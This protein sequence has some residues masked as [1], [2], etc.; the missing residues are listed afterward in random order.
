[1]SSTVP[2]PLFST[3]Q[4]HIVENTPYLSASLSI[5]GSSMIVYRIFSDRAKTLKKPYE[6]LILGLSCMDITGSLG[7]V[8]F[9]PWAAPKE[10]TWVLGARGTFTTCTIKG[11][12]MSS[13][14]GS[15]WYSAMMAIYFLL[16]VRFECRDQWIARRVEL[17]MHSISILLPVV[18][19]TY[20]A[21][22]GY[23][24][25][26]Y[27]PPGSCYV[28]RYPPLCGRDSRDDPAVE[29]TRGQNMRKF[30]LLMGGA[31]ISLCFGIIIVCMALIFARVRATEIKQR[32][33]LPEGASRKLKLTRQTSIQ[34][35]YYIGAFFLCNTWN[36]AYQL[37]M[38]S[39]TFDDYEKDATKWFI[40]LLLTRVFFPLQGTKNDPTMGMSL[41]SFESIALVTNIISRCFQVSSTLTFISANTSRTQKI[42]AT[43]NDPGVRGCPFT[44]RV[45][46]RPTRRRHETATMSKQV[47]KPAPQRKLRPFV[48]EREPNWLWKDTENRAEMTILV[49]LSVRQS[50]QDIAKPCL[51][52]AVTHFP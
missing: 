13:F 23:M 7:F 30:D 2:E 18:G 32:E 34:A 39:K 44:E 35:L 27:F 37:A 19:G 42:P 50:C 52:F 33:H 36:V 9:G 45:R 49:V 4:S 6:R 31:Q 38:E 14:V 51:S 22:K 17:P 8:V 16:V 1:M 21:I 3:R 25:P 10:A 40:L 28:T 15:A 12:L 48:S 20:A 24:N 11:W 47:W 5:L 41:S 43:R 46:R 26:L 29:C